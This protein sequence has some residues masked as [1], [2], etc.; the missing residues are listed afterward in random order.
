MVDASWQRDQVS[1]AHGNSDPAVLLVPD[2]KV[3]PAV[4]DVADLVVQVQVFLKEHL[5]LKGQGDTTVWFLSNAEETDHS[6][7]AP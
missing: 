7:T 2:V 3:G 6:F 5:Q 1:L 4:Q